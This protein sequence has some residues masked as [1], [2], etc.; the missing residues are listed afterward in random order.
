MNQSM[1]EE[2]NKE[3]NNARAVITIHFVLV[4]HQDILTLQGLAINQIRV[5][6]LHEEQKALIRTIPS[7]G[8]M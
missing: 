1:N 5:S 4:D 8:L 6:S 3:I 7:W 2:M